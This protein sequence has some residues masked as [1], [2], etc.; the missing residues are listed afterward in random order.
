MIQRG[1][2]FGRGLMVD[3]TGGQIFDN[4]SANDIR[5]VDLTKV[6]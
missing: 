3:W 1:I 5:D 4:D 6:Y 2:V